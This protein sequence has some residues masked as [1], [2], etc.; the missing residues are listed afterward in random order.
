[1][2]DTL[3]SILR[4]APVPVLLLVLWQWVTATGWMPPGA[5]ASPA[6]TLA[7][8]GA[9]IADG[10]LQDALAISLRRASIGFAIGGSL[11]LLLGLLAGFWRLGE[12][13]IDGS[14]QML[15]TVP[16]VALAPLFIVW[17]GI[18]ESAKIALI[19]FATLFPLYV[20][21]YAG[22]RSIDGRLLEA[23]RTLGLSR[24]ELVREIV[25]PGALPGILVG[26]R[27]SLALSVIALVIAE[28]INAD[29]GLG[30]LLLDARRFVQTDVMA[31]CIAIY[32]V[33][34]LLTNAAA[35]LLEWRLLS[36]RSGVRAS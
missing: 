23:G 12:D 11:G 13:L 7:T 32:A 36:W 26:L 35:Q 22:V 5:L 31:L 16:F 9:L 34:G 2:S 10:T 24:A 17:F 28:Q 6:A 33:L 20:N 21:T 3:S 30:A 15:R 1:M 27:Y 25:L 8:A 19:V 29:A 14:M 18:D 4:R